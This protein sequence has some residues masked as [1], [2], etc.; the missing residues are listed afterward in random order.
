MKLSPHYTA[1]QWKDAFVGCENWKLAIDIAED[2]IRGRWLTWADQISAAQFSGFAVLALDCI[3][4]ES[5]WGFMNGNPVPNGKVRDT[6]REILRGPRFGWTDAQSEAFREFVRNGLMHD[7]ETRS[8]W[9]V[10]R[11]LPKN[12]IIE[13]RP[14]AGYVINRTKFHD[15]LKS[16]FDDWIANLRDGDVALRENMRN[17]MKQIITTHYAP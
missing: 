7:A 2:R 6:Y 1:K 3:I 13:Q 14:G 12:S 10:Q 4:L 9:I 17:R 8:Q 5:L 15:A 11:T 16:T